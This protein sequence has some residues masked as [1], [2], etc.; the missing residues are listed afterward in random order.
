MVV[1]EKGR[2]MNKNMKDSHSIGLADKVKMYPTPTQ[3]DHKDTGILKA[4]IR[5]DGRNRLDTLGRVVGVQTEHLKIAGKT[6]SLNSDW[7]TW[8]M[9]YPENWVNLE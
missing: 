9:G 4:K 1:N 3:R 6:P 5:K 8:L 7:V 2:R